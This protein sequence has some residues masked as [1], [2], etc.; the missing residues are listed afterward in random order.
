MRLAL[1]ALSLLLATP[2]AAE[3]LPEDAAHAVAS[4][5]I[6]QALGQQLDSSVLTLEPRIVLPWPGG[7]RVRIAATAH[8]LPVVGW[9]R[10][11]AVDPAGRVLREYGGPLPSGPVDL[12]FPIARERALEWGATIAGWHG[13]GELWPARAERVVLAEEGRLHAIWQVDVSA[14]EPVGSW[15]LRV[16][17]NDGRLRAWFPTM[18]SATGNVYPENPIS[19]DLA[20]VELLRLWNEDELV[21][22]HAAVQSCVQVEAQSPGG[23]ICTTKE[24]FADGGA[25]GDFLYTPDPG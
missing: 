6:D 18:H 7:A 20:E 14:A 12:S 9:E 3:A 2:A 17:A 15:Q 13:E 11:L 8:G 16:D 19:S 4:G 5:W 10:V 22:T 25:D 1:V 21:G 23:N 24:R